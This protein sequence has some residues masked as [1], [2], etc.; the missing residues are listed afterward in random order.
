MTHNLRPL[1]RFAIRTYLH[2]S[3]RLL[4]LH[5]RRTLW[6]VMRVN[7]N[8]DLSPTHVRLLPDSNSNR[9]LLPYAYKIRFLTRKRL[10][11]HAGWSC[12]ESREILNQTSNTFT[13]CR[14]H[15]Y[16]N[17]A[18]WSSNSQLSATHAYSV[19]TQADRRLAS[20]QQTHAPTS[21]QLRVEELQFSARG[22]NNHNVTELHEFEPVLSPYIV[23]SQNS[24]SVQTEPT[25]SRVLNL[26]SV[27]WYS[28]RLLTT[29]NVHSSQSMNSMG[30]YCNDKRQHANG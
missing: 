24:F 29:Q 18:A 16:S 15:G 20:A 4:Q 21:R 27:G 26:Q 1:H 19:P 2:I 30:T 23:Q 9:Q 3:S 17:R 28:N 8:C 7:Q 13:F 5:A 11:Q 22:S 12:S 10:P 25:S 6:S 14:T